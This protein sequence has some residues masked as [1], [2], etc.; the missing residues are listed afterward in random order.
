MMGLQSLDIAQ[1]TCADIEL[2][3]MI[4]KKQMA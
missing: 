4:K 1:S 3:R 2:L